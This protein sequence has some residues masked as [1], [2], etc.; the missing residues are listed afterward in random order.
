MN[1]KE[2]QLREQMG[3]ALDEMKALTAK[4]ESEKRAPTSDEL[5][6]HL[7]AYN[8]A[9]DLAKQIDAI[10]N[11]AEIEGVATRPA[12]QPQATS[13]KVSDAQSEQELRM[14]TAK[15]LTVAASKS[16]DYGTK[17]TKI[18]EAQEKLAEAGHYRM[19]ADGFNTLVD[20]DGGIFLPTTISDEVFNL[21]RGFG[22][23]SR[24]SNRF[25]TGGGRIKI[26]NIMGDLT[27]SAVNETSDILVDEFQFKGLELDDL[28]WGLFLPW[29]NEVE[30]VRGAQLVSIFIAKLAEAYAKLV[31]N[32]VI[33]ANGTSTFHNIQGLVARAGV[34]TSPWVRKSAAGSGR[35]TFAA[36]LAEDWNNARKDVAPSLISTGIYVAHP[37]RQIELLNELS[38]GSNANPV[39]WV[40]QIGDQ[41]FV[42]GRPI[43][44]TEAFPNSDGS[45][46]PYAAYVDPRY[47]AVADAGSFVTELFTEATIKTKSGGTINLASQDM[48]ALRIKAFMDVELG[49][50]TV[51]DGGVQRGAFT[52]LYTA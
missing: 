15:I 10:R 21:S 22:V 44:F 31:D 38:K 12:L 29:S 19:S 32:V 20:T 35:N 41:M 3:A 30:G 26:P 47:I 39:K 48:K 28:K 40:T 46:V 49:N 23:F 37:H 25:P 6:L 27:F 43:Y 24:F 52:V 42:H 7:S 8:R 33:N 14:Y 16:M 51:T 11:E 17:M 2:R 18:K 9:N 50:A 34:A 5:E 45:N 1:Q 4:A 13:T 36:V